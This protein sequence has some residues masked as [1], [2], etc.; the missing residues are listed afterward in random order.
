MNYGVM[1]LYKLSRKCYLNKIPIIPK[2]IKLFIRV[3]FGAT[4]PYKTKIGDGTRFPHGASGVVLHEKAEIGYN[5]KIQTNVVIGGRN[6]LEGAPKIGNNV[7]IGAGAV[8][9]G[10][11]KIGNNVSIGANAVVTHDIGE[12][13]VAVGVP[14]KVVRAKTEKEIEN[15]AV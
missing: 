14:A 11:I 1:K 13:C 2:L 8:I 6:G 5:C 10:N 15:G 7:L 4:I 3:I 12:N 9:I